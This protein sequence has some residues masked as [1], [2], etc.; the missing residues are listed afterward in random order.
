[1]DITIKAVLF[2]VT[3]FMDNLKIIYCINS[4]FYIIF[5]IYKVV[6]INMIFR[7]GSIYHEKNRKGDWFKAANQS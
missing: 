1:M 5:D 7:W 6:F 4:V 2:I 3:L